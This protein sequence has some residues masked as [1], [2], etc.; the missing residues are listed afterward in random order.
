MT[1]IAT[2]PPVG[3]P[4][5]ADEPTDAHPAVPAADSRADLAALLVKI[6]TRRPGPVNLAALLVEVTG[7]PIEAFADDDPRL[8]AREAGELGIRLLAEANSADI[9]WHTTALNGTGER[10]IEDQVAE[11]LGDAHAALDLLRAVHVMLKR[12]NGTSPSPRVP[13]T[14]PTLAGLLT[15]AFRLGRAADPEA[16]EDKALM[17]ARIAAGPLG[18]PWIQAERLV[19]GQVTE[20]YETGRGAEA[21]R[22]EFTGGTR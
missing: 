10:D 7:R 12:L 14:R 2:V 11:F 17:G 20:A 9:Y 15:E 8:L 21:A 6:S 13:D 5:L 22:H 18:D 3:Q 4:P 1:I 16:D 19:D